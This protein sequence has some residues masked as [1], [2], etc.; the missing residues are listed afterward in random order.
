MV[1]Y[2]PLA[3]ATA[4]ALI[5]VAGRATRRMPDVS[6]AAVGQGTAGSARWT[7]QWMLALAVGA[8]LLWSV[9]VHLGDDLKASRILRHSRNDYLRQ[10]RPFI[11]DHSAVFASGAIKDSFGPLLLDLD[12]VI[13]APGLDRGETAQELTDALLT[14]GR[15]VYFLPNALPPELFDRV[16][17]GR[18]VRPHG[19]QPVLLLEVA[20]P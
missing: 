4:L 14:Q 20:P 11:T 16:L 12:V 5:W 17:A 13:A 19:E 2:I 10:L 8:A 18:K 1:M 3:L 6:D 7:M 15:R 9:A